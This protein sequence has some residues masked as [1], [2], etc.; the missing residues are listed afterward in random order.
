MP[1]DTGHAAEK[2]PRPER[3]LT[4]SPEGAGGFPLIV[5]DL[6]E[7]PLGSHC[8]ELHSSEDE[9]ADHAAAFLAGADDPKATSYWV[10]DDKLLAF[11][12][13]R[14][15]RRD[16]ALPTVLHTLEGPQAV[17]TDGKLRPTREVIRFIRAHPEGVTAGAATITRYWSREQIPAYLEYE[18]WFHQQARDQSRFLCP[19][20]LR[21][22][23]VDLA[24]T[25]LPELVSHHSHLTLST[26][27]H[28]MALLVQFLAFPSQARVPEDLRRAL[29]W[30]VQEGLIELKGAERRPVLALKGEAFAAAFQSFEERVRAAPGLA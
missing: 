20:D 23:P 2:T 14:M 11:N 22:V 8:L 18:Q 1:Q 15:A 29:A 25:V 4:P 24:P 10:A 9:A 21:R 16:P 12:Q 5:Q 3:S 30:S 7:L 6:S 13:D 19:Y 27:P 26:G 17:P 28:P